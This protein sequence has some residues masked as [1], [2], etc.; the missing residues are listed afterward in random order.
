MPPGPKGVFIALPRSRSR[1]AVARGQSK[2]SDLAPKRLHLTDNCSKRMSS[3]ASSA[4]IA[5]TAFILFTS[6][7]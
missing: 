6:F 1:E 7:W 3:R 5:S 2:G 4:A